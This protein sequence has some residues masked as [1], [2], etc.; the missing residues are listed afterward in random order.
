MPKL[1][2]LLLITAALL[3][4]CQATPEQARNN[5]PFFS[6]FSHKD[7]D[8]VSRCI[9]QGWSTTQV[10]EKDATT[11]LDAKTDK[12][13]VYTWQNSLFTDIYPRG[14]GAEVKFYKTFDMWPGVLAD[15]SRIVKS[16]V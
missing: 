1:N 8:S 13:S 4:G 5:G 11:H 6:E 14:S 7:A 10:V 2:L 3:A 9:Y 16:C 15:R 12:T